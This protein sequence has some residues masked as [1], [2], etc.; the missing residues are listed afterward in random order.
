[1]SFKTKGIF[2][3]Y[4]SSKN[5]RP[6]QIRFPLVTRPNPSFLLCMPSFLPSLLPSIFPSIH[7]SI[8]PFFLPS[9]ACLLACLLPSFLPFFHSSFLTSLLPGLFLW[10]DIYNLNQFTL[11]Y[12]SVPQQVVYFTATFPLIIIV[13]MVI[14][15]VTLDGAG[16]GL[17]FYLKPDFRR[18]ADP[19]VPLLSLMNKLLKCY[20]FSQ[21]RAR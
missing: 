8:L 11:M 1:M 19:Q 18:L 6:G 7:P 4:H 10:K 3:S 16:D 9:L 14:R 12:S 17:L 21:A 5:Q 2:T 20:I 13:V 15:G